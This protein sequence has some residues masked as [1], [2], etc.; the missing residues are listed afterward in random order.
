MQD[1]Y[2]LTPTEQA[3]RFRALFKYLERQYMDLVSNYHLMVIPWAR[4]PIIDR[5]NRTARLQGFELVRVSLLDT[6]I[7]AITRL[8]LDGDD[9]NPSLCTM[10]RPFLRGN[11]H[12][13]A[14]L[15]QILEHDYSDWHRRIGS[16]ER[17]NNPKW[18]IQML[19]EQGEKDAEACRKEFWERADTIAADWPKLIKAS[20]TFH[21]VR[22]KWIAHFE[23]EFDP[24]TKEYKPVKLPALREV[25]DGIEAVVPTITESVSHLAGLI[26]SLDISPDQFA[27][28]AKQSAAAFWEVE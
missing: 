1:I 18:V 13:R 23:V 21:D 22:N 17:Q 5:F 9:T 24:G 28:V 10:M 20:E 2:L 12:K 27:G 26:K 15:L 6:C 3:E 11:R 7:L 4:Q 14:E 19:E 25:Y 8:L 16:E